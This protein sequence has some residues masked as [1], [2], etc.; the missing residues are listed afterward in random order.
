MGARYYDPTRARFMSPDTA[1]PN[2]AFT[3]AANRYA[4]A[5]GNPLRWTDPTGHQP[6]CSVCEFEED[7][8][9]DGVGSDPSEWAP[10]SEDDGI[11]DLS[12]PPLVEAK[13][14]VLQ[15]DP[16]EIKGVMRMDPIAIKGVMRMD[17][18]EIKGSPSGG[19][20]PEAAPTSEYWDPEIFVWFSIEW[21]REK[22][23]SIGKDRTLQLEAMAERIDIFS[24]EERE[25][26]ALVEGGYGPLLSGAYQTHPTT[27]DTGSYFGVRAGP[28]GAGFGFN[29]DL[30]KWF[31]GPLLG[32]EGNPWYDTPDQ[33]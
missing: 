26:I 12:A 13:G 7:V 27:T 5:Y 16:I 15:M 3:Q 19:S 4:Y 24:K 2:P 30:L 10:W 23:I 32:P 33:W 8:T 20:E 22:D 1:L 28:F 6:E 11:D 29:I 18:I 25:V 21:K 9:D 17:P 14:Q 31:I